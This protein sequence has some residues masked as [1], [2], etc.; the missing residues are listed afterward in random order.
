LHYLPVALNIHGRRTL[1]I[2]GGVVGTQ[3]ARDFL[4]AGAEVTIVSP[5]VSDWIREQ[6]DAGHV[7]LI[8][9]PYQTG[10]T[11]GYFLVVV[12]TDDREANAAAYVEANAADRL[13][14]VCDDPPHCNYIFASVISRGP[15]TLS[16][17]THGTSPALSRRVRREL[18]GWLG[19]EYAALAE[20][21]AE[22]RPRVMAL[23]GLDQPA[24][25]RI[26]ERIVYSEALLLLREGKVDEARALAERAI[27][28]GSIE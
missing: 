5:V 24:R 26:F 6:A 19:P 25:Q 14:N 22:L 17:F 23:P 11:E 10:D 13:V 27:A 15:L 16:I 18:E 28:E 7:T 9:R 2:G 4:S 8:E 21:M 3:K 12:A 20:L 1:V